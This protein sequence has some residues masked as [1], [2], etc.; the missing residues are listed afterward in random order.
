MP[1]GVSRDA[2][3]DMIA[4]TLDNYAPSGAFE[5][6]QEFPRYEVVNRWMSKDRTTFTGG[7]SITRHV[8]LDEN[9]TAEMVS[10]YQKFEGAQVDLM[11]TV[12]APLT[13]CKSEYHISREEMLANMSE[14]RIVNLI[15]AKRKPAMMSKCNKLERQGFGVPQ[16]SGDAL[17]AYGLPYWISLGPNGSYAADFVGQTI[18]FGDDST[19]TIKGGLDGSTAGN[20]MFRNY[21][22][23]YTGFNSNLVNQMQLLW[24]NLDF[25]MPRNV[26]ETGE[27]PFTDYRIYMSLA[28]TSNY[29]SMAT[30]GNDNLGPDVSPYEGDSLVFKRTP[31][32]PIKLLDSFSVADGGGT[33]FN[34]EPIYFVNHSRFRTFCQQG[35][36]FREDGPYNDRSQPLVYTTYFFTMFQFLCDNVREGGAVL[37][38]QIPSS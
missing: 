30:S 34:P 31:I 10:P 15:E 7:K 1:N 37:H 13:M 23:L 35:E 9:G 25:R 8:V 16:S 32:I 6:I 5:M 12:T 24:L 4:T 11:Q 38:K 26:K 18:R 22:G 29:M 2:L 28:N 14:E 19:G 21:A 20:S 36:F 17:N 3:Y 33:A 27:R